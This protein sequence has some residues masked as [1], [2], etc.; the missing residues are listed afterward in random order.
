VWLLVQNRIDIVS[1]PRAIEE[2]GP[3][4]ECDGCIGT[5][6]PALPKRR[7]LPD[8]DTVAGDDE[9]LPAI[10]RP[11]DLSALVP[12]LSLADLSCHVS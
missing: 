1:E 4:E 3:C 12:K 11:H 8:G 5:H 6:E 10:E 7:Q 2:W 9:R